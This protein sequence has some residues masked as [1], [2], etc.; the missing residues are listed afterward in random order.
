MKFYNALILIFC[1]VVIRV[2]SL[3]GKNGGN[4]PGMIALK[5]N[6]N[7]LKYFSIKGCVIAVTGTNGKT[8]T[9]NLICETLSLDG[10]VICNREGN[11]INTGITS[12]LVRNCN[13]FGFINCDYLVL[14]V[15]EHYV[16]VV[17]R[18]LKLDTFVVL[19]FFRDQLDRTGEVETLIMKINTFLSGYDGN[20][21]LNSDDPNVLRLKYANLDNDNIYLFSVSRYDGANKVMHDKG[22]GKFCPKCFTRL[23]YDYYQYSHIGKFRC[24]KCDFG[25]GDIFLNITDIDLGK[26][27]FICDGKLFKTQYSS[28][29]N[30]YNIAPVLCVAK[31]YDINFDD[32]SKVIYDYKLNN[33]RMESVVVDGKI[34]VMNLAKNPT[35]ANVSLRYMNQD[36]SV[37]ELL[38]VLNDNIADGRDVSWIWDVNFDVLNNVSRVITSGTRAYDM[39]VRIK[40]SGFDVSNIECYPDIGDAVCALY[41]TDSSK[42]VIFNYTAVIETR[43]RILEYK[44]DVK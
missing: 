10:K 38:F 12:L 43:N 8:S 29:Y 19:N 31:L 26:K 21:I 27:T 6:R 15:D 44:G 42:Y 37:K 11:N 20:L 5:L 33:G 24:P 18:D 28:I 1:K 2:L 3:F 35:G 39:A 13:I 32:V 30:F 22:E 23:K 7:L 9:T 14:E 41:K 4:L 36:D 17:F 40:S 16:P 25:V 34:T